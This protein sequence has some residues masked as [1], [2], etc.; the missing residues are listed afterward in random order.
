MAIP[1]LYQL[2]NSNYTS[3]NNTDFRVAVIDM[4][5][6]GLSKDQITQLQTQD[7]TLF[8]YISIGEAEDYRDYWTDNGWSNNKPGFLLGENPDWAG[9]FLVKFWDPAWQNIMFSRVE[10]AVNLGYDGM[11]LDIV[12][13]YQVAQVQNAYTGDDIRQD[14]IDFVV[15]LS[16][17]AKSINPD[18]KVIP[19]NAVGLLGITEDNPDVPNTAYLNA[20][21]GLGVEDLWFDDNRNADWTQGD[22]EFIQNALNADKFVLATSYPTQDAQQ[23]TFINNALAE[24]M[25][26]FAG[27]R[28][29]NGQIDGQNLDILAKM[30]GLNINF[31]DDATTSP[32]PTPTPNARFMNN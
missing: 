27:N 16:Q 11:Y 17:Y 5:D 24:G 18:F 6:A 2:Q 29:L 30:A 4:D 22:L 19:Q 15:A 9:N 28:D 26:P 32:T 14:M 25:I 10:K 31:P 13:A 7:K 1:F 8:T 12:D 21:D 3:L 20:I 23:I